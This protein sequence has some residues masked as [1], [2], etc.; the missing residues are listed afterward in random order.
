M[1]LGGTCRV[2]TYLV[3]PADVGAGSIVNQATA[4][5]DQIGPVTDDETTPLQVPT[6]SVVKP[7]PVLSADADGSEHFGG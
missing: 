5:S 7:A 2:G 3:T 1:T 6:L 4:V